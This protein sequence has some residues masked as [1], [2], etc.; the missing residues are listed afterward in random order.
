MMQMLEEAKVHKVLCG[1][2]A[3]KLIGGGGDQILT[4]VNW[5]A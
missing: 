2:D 4:K 3:Y 5:H 1:C